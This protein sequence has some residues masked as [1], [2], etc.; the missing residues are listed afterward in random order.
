M[1]CIPSWPNYNENLMLCTG[2]AHVT[3]CE[4]DGGGPLFGLVEGR[5]ELV[6]II[7]HGFHNCDPSIGV[8]GVYTR[9]SVYTDWI[10]ETKLSTG[11]LVSPSCFIF[12]IVIFGNT[13]SD[14]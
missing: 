10:E 12:I 4:G 8:N 3:A 7:S 6:G 9:V 14:K 1:D 2:S 13:L 11:N 5:R